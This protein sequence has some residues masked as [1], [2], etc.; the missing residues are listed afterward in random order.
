MPAAF[1][2]DISR[3]EIIRLYVNSVATNKEIGANII[4]ILGYP[5]AGNDVFGIELDNNGAIIKAVL[6]VER[7]EDANITKEI[8]VLLEL[9]NY[10]ILNIPQINPSFDIIS[11]SFEYSIFI[12]VNFL[13]FQ[14]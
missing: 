2:T 7:Q 10:G 4:K 6:K 12:Q 14:N 1:I 3:S 8:S 9:K 5:H 13:M 11:A